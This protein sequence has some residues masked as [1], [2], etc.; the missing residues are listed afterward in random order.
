[1]ARTIGIAN[2]KG[3]VGKTTTAINLAASFA[4]LEYRTLLVDADPQA[5]STTGIGFDLHNITQSLYDCMVNEAQAKDVILK[6]DIPNLDLMPSHIDLVGAEI[7]MINYPNRESVL[8]QILEPVKEEYDFIVIDCSPSLGLITVNALTAADSVV[9]PVQTEFFALEGLGKLLNTIKIVQN[10]LNPSLK[11][12]GILMTMYD[13]RLRLCNQ[14]VSE[15]RRHFE[16]MVFSS[17]IH[18]NTRL[19]EAPSFGKPVI[20][21]DAESKGSVNYLNLAREILQ[22]NNLTKINQ[23]EKILE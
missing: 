3:G 2:Q 20:L 14:V 18:R 7:E 19:S 13:G 9:V 6:S 22:K 5:N 11:I 17:I 21:Y 4:V 12:E 1:M 16:D 23:A 8:K 15:V 10:R